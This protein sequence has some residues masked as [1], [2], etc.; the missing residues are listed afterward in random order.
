MQL[1]DSTVNSFTIEAVISQT[2]L[3]KNLIVMI[4]EATEDLQQQKTSGR[5]RNIRDKVCHQLLHIT[6]HMEKLDASMEEFSPQPLSPPPTHAETRLENIENDIKEIKAALHLSSIEAQINDLKAALHETPKTWAT[7]VSN[8]SKESLS[9]ATKAR[10]KRR[11][12]QEKLRK[13]REP[14]EVILT[15]TNNTTTETLTTMNAHMIN[16]CCQNLIDHTIAEKPKLNGI[17]RIT[18]GI[19]LQCKSPEDAEILRRKLDWSKAFDGLAVYKPKYGIVVHGVPTKELTGLEDKDIHGELMREWEEN[20]NGI[21][22]K[23]I[24]HLR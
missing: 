7:I 8:T 10:I 17:N 15:T 11:E 1:N 23:A 5:P 4:K 14:F 3:F 24:K 12:T 13:E 9:T 2:P 16:E 6:L 22:I 18:N 21:K 19:R 20:N